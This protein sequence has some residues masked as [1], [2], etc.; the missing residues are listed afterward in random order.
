MRRSGKDLL[1]TT[2]TT[3]RSFTRPKFEYLFFTQTM[4]FSRPQKAERAIFAVREVVHDLPVYQTRG[5][6][7]AVDVGGKQCLL[8]WKGVFNEG[9]R[10]LT[11][12]K[13]VKFHQ[14]SRYKEKN[15]Q[16]GKSKIGQAGSFSFI[17]AEGLQSCDA[18][19]LIVPGSNVIENDVCAQ[20][21]IGGKKL[22][23]FKFQYIKKE[24]KHVLTSF[25]GKKCTIEKFAVLGSPIINDKSVIGVV[26]EDADG[27]LIP[28]F[29]TQTELGKFVF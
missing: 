29:I 7:S 3:L 11:N 16:L 23:K 17:P 18:L 20:S 14:S 8:T 21:F 26:G 12:H 13:P 15:H 5:M 10:A 6:A 28:C 4:E 1:L 22:L 19:M 27:Q 24:Q 2:W 25:E 9:D